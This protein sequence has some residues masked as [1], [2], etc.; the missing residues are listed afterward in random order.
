LVNGH[1]LVKKKLIRGYEKRGEQLHE[2]K[3][4]K[5]VWVIAQKRVQR[6]KKH[7]EKLRDSHLRLYQAKSKHGKKSLIKK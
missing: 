4:N 3:N 7:P 5:K 2:N 6:H 1:S